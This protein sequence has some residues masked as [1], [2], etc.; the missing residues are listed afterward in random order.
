MNTRHLYTTQDENVLVLEY[1]VNVDKVEIES[2]AELFY[3]H[4]INGEYFCVWNVELK[5]PIYG[6]LLDDSTQEVSFYKTTERAELIK[7][8]AAI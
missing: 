3:V 4:M 8:L 5:V 6:M 1:V 7:A 2:G